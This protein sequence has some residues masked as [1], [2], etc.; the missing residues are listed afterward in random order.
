LAAWPFFHI[1][2]IAA[3]ALP[4]AADAAAEPI[5]ILILKEIDGESLGKQ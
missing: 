3:F 4:Y 2:V 5:E 1:H